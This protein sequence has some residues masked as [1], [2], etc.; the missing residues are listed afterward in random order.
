MSCGEENMAGSTVSSGR[1]HEEIQVTS[2]D[3][4][5]QTSEILAVQPEQALLN[6]KSHNFDMGSMKFTS[7]ARDPPSPR[8]IGREIAIQ[9]TPIPRRAYRRRFKSDC[10]TCRQKKIRCDRHQPTCMRFPFTKSLQPRH[11]ANRILQVI[12]VQRVKLHAK[13]TNYRCLHRYTKV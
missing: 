4:R 9:S 5:T 10:L 3:K 7:D 2:Q 11:L 12:I 1:K 8:V 6:Q 13:A